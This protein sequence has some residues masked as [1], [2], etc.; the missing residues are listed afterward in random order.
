[1]ELTTLYFSHSSH[2][3]HAGRLSL[4]P[5]SVQKA[6]YNFS[7]VYQ[8]KLHM[9]SSIGLAKI[10]LHSD[11][12]ASVKCASKCSLAADVMLPAAH[13]LLITDM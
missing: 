3:I 6:Y 9:Q 11:G 2:F 5:C 7:I 10:A 12:G 8:I 4:Y 13:R 1:M